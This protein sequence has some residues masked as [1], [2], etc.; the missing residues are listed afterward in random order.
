[1]ALI[2]ISRDCIYILLVLF[3][4]IGIKDVKLTTDYSIVDRIIQLSNSHAV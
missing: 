2:C 4:F 1:M 3:A